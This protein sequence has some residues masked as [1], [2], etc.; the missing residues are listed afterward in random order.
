M[1]VTRGSVR[2]VSFAV[3]ERPFLN[4]NYCYN[5]TCIGIFNKLDYFKYCNCTKLLKQQT[6]IYKW[7]YCYPLLVATIEHA[8]KCKQ[9]SGVAR[10][11]NRTCFPNT[12]IFLKNESS[13]FLQALDSLS[14]SELKGEFLLY[15]IWAICKRII[16]IAMLSLARKL[17]LRIKWRRNW[18]NILYIGLFV[19]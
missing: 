16:K 15:S 8:P 19:K 18:A 9:S 17:Y 5:F 3:W 2:A 1:E 11:V 10:N 12:V 4:T 13:K 6:A 7:G 14:N